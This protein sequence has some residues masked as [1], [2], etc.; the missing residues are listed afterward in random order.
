MGNGNWKKKNFINCIY[1]IYFNESFSMVIFNE[2]RVYGIRL[3]NSVAVSNRRYRQKGAQWQAD[4]SRPLAERTFSFY[5]GGTGADV[6]CLGHLARNLMFGSENGVFPPEKCHFIYFMGNWCSMLKN[7]ALA[8][9][10]HGHHLKDPLNLGEAQICRASRS[11]EMAN[12]L[13]RN[14][15]IGIPR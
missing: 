12:G 2:Q 7:S 8:M 1:L 11:L 14:R 9:E 5:Y 15:V 4:V 6:W 10:F 3:Q 13:A